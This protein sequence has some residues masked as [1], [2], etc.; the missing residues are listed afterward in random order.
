MTN[1]RPTLGISVVAF[2]DLDGPV[3][4]RQPGPARGRIRPG[5]RR[6]DPRVC[7]AGLGAARGDRGRRNLLRARRP[8]LAA[9][10]ATNSVG[11]KARTASYAFFGGV[12]ASTR[13]ADLPKA[14]TSVK[15]K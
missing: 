9:A 5:H 11:G 6:A 15:S 10:F 1:S 4:L 3:D 14:R 8:D 13:P 7:L 12:T 2:E